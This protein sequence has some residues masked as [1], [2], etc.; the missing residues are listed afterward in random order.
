MK[1]HTL[2]ALTTFTAASGSYGSL[3]FTGVVD[4]TQTG[5]IPKA[6]E[7]MS[8]VDGTELSDFFILRDTNG[9]SGGPFTVSSDFQLP[10]GTL[11]AGEFYYIYGGTSSETIMEGFGIGNTDTNAVVDGI[12]NQNGDDI[13]AISTSLLPADV[14]D[15]FG[16]LGQGDTDFYANSVSYRQAGTDANPTGVADGGNFDISAYSDASLQATFGTYVIPEPTTAL[17]GG[18]GFLALLRR[19]R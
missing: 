15:G 13:L 12:A 7:I 1:F 3:I 6:I 10:A 19:R 5:G 4:G 2:L 16:L 17:L 8:T 9:T 18:L 14:V 11:D